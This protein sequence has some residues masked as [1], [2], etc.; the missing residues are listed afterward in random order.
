MEP[1]LDHPAKVRHKPGQAGGTLTYC[2]AK[3]TEAAPC[4]LI[5][6]LLDTCLDL[7][8]V[9]GQAQDNLQYTEVVKCTSSW[10]ANEVKQYA[11]GQHC[12]K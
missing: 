12:K 8:P 7:A 5:N 4:E 9:V 2:Q 1:V 3:C 11:D 6:L 10:L